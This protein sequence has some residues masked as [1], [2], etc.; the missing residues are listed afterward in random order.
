MQNKSEYIHHA[1]RPPVCVGINGEHVDKIILNK[2]IMRISSYKLFVI[3][4]LEETII[5]TAIRENLTCKGGNISLPL[6]IGQ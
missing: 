5:N 3:P 1:I 2:D 6:A 4:Q